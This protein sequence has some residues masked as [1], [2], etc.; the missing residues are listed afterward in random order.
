MT[1]FGKHSDLI[2]RSDDPFNGGP[3]PGLLRRH[4]I[5]PTNLFFVR[6]HAPVPSVDPTTYRL[7]VD[8]L[9][10]APLQLSL[11]D[12]RARF[13]RVTVAATV[14]CAGNRRREL[15]ALKP[16]PG[17][18]PWDTE[19]ISTAE[20]GG[21]PLRAVLDAAGVQPTSRHVAFIGLDQVEKNGERFGFGGSIPIEKAMSPEVL[22]ADTMNGEPLPPT[23]GFPLRVLVPGF[24][25][26]RSVKW[27]GGITLQAEPS[28]NYYRAHSYRLFPPE[29]TDATADWEQGQ[30]IDDL[31]VNAAITEP[32][33]GAAVPAGAL[34]VRGYA[35]AGSGHAVA[36]VEVSPDGEASWTPATLSGDASPWTWRFWEAQVQLAAGSHE[37]VARA[38][39]AAGA[40]QP[41]DP[42]SIWNFKGYMNNAWH[43]V[44]VTVRA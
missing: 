16:V 43:R 15:M 14:V 37:L 2:V 5:T 21:T 35:I 38:F 36:R 34:T 18:V 3:P 40:V 10:R 19:A 27:L 12:L 20:W 11:D 44:P 1:A 33:P 8:G 41:P 22:L 4:F 30:V 26:A 6:N 24:V 7:I 23:H 17:E 9:V 28:Q 13:S 39:D 25:G 31:S 29:V 42:R 32:L